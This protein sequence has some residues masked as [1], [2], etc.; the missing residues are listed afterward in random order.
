MVKSLGSSVG[1]DL[2]SLS[3]CCTVAAAHESP[4][5]AATARAMKRRNRTSMDDLMGTQ[6]EGVN[7]H[8]KPPCHCRY[9]VY[10]SGVLV[11]LVLS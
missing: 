6:P 4:P 10:L 3:C 8:R 9:R 2:G 5:M 1:M 7:K 11:F